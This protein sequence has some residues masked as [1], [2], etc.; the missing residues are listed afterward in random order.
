M[1][2]WKNILIAKSV[3]CIHAA[4]R[5]TLPDQGEAARMHQKLQDV[6]PIYSETNTYIW[7]KRNQ[8]KSEF[9]YMEYLRYLVN[10]YSAAFASSLT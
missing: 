2:Q 7:E 9:N 4:E 1:F 6:S 10:A 8:L 3:Q 5:K